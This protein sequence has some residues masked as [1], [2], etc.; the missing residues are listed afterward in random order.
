MLTLTV[1]YLYRRYVKKRKEQ[2]ALALAT[3]AA[4]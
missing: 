2:R 3:L 1:I 4:A